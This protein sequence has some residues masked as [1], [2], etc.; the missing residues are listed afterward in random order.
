MI[1][2]QFH[3]FLAYFFLRFRF[4]AYLCTRGFYQTNI[5]IYISNYNYLKNEKGT[6]IYCCSP[7]HRV[8]VLQ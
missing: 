3:I 2:Y 1:I 5:V 4:F 7:N 8:G 6:P